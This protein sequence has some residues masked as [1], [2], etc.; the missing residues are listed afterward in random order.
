MGGA[1]GS[2]LFSGLFGYFIVPRLLIH[3][4]I[5]GLIGGIMSQFGDLTAS[6][7]KR[8]MGVK[9]YGNLIPGHGGIMDRFDSVI[10]MAPIIYYYIMIVL[11]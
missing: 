7:L 6:A 11:I 10:F 9:D 2:I 8:K 1:I 3:C 4:L 5:I